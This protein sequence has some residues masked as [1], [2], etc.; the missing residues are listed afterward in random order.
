MLQRIV[1]AVALIPFVATAWATNGLELRLSTPKP[2]YMSGELITVTLVRKNNGKDTLRLEQGRGL[3]EAVAV[4][5]PDG[6]RL[7]YRGVLACGGSK[8]YFDLRP[9]EARTEVY[10]LTGID[11]RPYDM[12][13]LGRYELQSN[14]SSVRETNSE[15]PQYIKY[16]E[17]P[18]SAPKIEIQI[19][20]VRP[21]E[22]P[23]FRILAKNGDRNAI[24]FLGLNKDP[25]AIPA[26]ETAYELD[27]WYSRFDIASAL[28]LI[29]T[30]EAV[31]ALARLSKSASKLERIVLLNA[32]GKSK[33]K[34]AIPV[35]KDYLKIDD[36][37]IGGRYDGKNNFKIL[38]T[39]KA[40]ADSLRAFK[41]DVPHSVWE[42]P[43]DAAWKAPSSE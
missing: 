23:N 25:G 35:L 33:N 22:Y 18:T 43:V 42:I 37:Y 32:L 9:A 7:P 10:N 20:K 13:R 24:Q 12:T 27:E 8:A 17:G 34:T 31:S 19:T 11:K 14:Y 36:D 38:G 5:G 40:A 21:S 4:I 30:D 2:S 15:L 39:R 28:A 29:G 41:I 1:S 3:P 26:L 16:W 6:K